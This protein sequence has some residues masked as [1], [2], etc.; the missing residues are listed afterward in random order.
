MTSV[1]W[2][3]KMLVAD[4]RTVGKD[5]FTDTA[6]KI[7]LLNEKRQTFAGDT[8]LAITGAGKLSIIIALRDLIIGGTSKIDLLAAIQFYFTASCLPGGA[9]VLIIGE[10]NNHLITVGEG[11]S[12]SS[13]T[14]SSY[15]KQTILALGDS[16][17]LSQG[18]IKL[19][20][21]ALDAV[22][23]TSLI[24][25]SVSP[26]ADV[27]KFTKSKTKKPEI[28]TVDWD[29]SN[30][31]MAWGIISDSICSSRVNEKLKHSKVSRTPLGI[32]EKL[33]RK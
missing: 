23:A 8:I 9:N 22:K 19:G 30:S 16:Y 13:T 11:F 29:T 7:F 20:G 31:N 21:S 28:Q 5:G 27:I 18:I 4:K 25:D 3:G 26:C 10:K 24:D 1:V 33:T 14:I 2:D 17:R 32:T 12:T 6:T 15:N